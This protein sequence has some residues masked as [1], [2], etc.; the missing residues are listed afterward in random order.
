MNPD[1]A[2]IHPQMFEVWI[3]GDRGQNLSPDGFRRAAI[4]AYIDSMPLTE[5][6]GR[7]RQGEPVRAIPNTGFDELP[8]I[9]R[10]YTAIAGFAGQKVFDA[11]PLVIAQN[12]TLPHHAESKCSITCTI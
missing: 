7:S 9:G 2:A 8:V 6:Q 5:G 10:C 4:I 1:N 3:V 11:L 12:H